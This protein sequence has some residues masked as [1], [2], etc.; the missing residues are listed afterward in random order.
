AYSLR[1]QSH[2][3]AP[4]LCPNSE[5]TAYTSS[6]TGNPPANS[7]TSALAHPRPAWSK[8]GFLRQV[9]TDEKSPSIMERRQRLCPRPGTREGATRIRRHR[10]TDDRDGGCRS[11][12]HARCTA[13]VIGGP[14]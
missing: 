12:Q 2:Y 6:L 11:H 9:T 3:V 7:K 1:S 10:F 8:R 4:T 5:R 13:R 14:G